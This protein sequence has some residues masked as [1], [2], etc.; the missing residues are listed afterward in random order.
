MGKAALDLPDPMQSPP[1][2]TQTSTD[3]LLA[4]LAGEEIDRLLS[5]ADGSEPAPAAAKPA[6]TPLEF[7][8]DPT[9][10]APAGNGAVNIDPG[11]PAPPLP[12]LDVTA[13]LDELFSSAIAKDKTADEA[14]GASDAT[15]VA[16]G[17]VASPEDLPAGTTAAERAG[18]STPVADT[19]KAEGAADAAAHPLADV[20]DLNR[21][22]PAYLRPLEW[23]NA[24]LASSPPSIR[25][26]I[27]KAAIITLFN[28]AAILVYVMLFRR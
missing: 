15:A 21:P 1:P 8:P 6:P 23:L 24:P 19:A 7:P 5:E 3:D 4:Q 25:D 13:E 10:A 27:G 17:P 11:A 2:G 22:L 14:A 18:L 20:A 9:S 28:A 12:E 16:R 26:L